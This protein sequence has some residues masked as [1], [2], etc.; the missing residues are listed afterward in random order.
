MGISKGFAPSGR[1]DEISQRNIQ[2]LRS[3]TSACPSSAFWPNFARRDGFA[4]ARAA[5]I[6]QESER[7][8]DVAEAVRFV[9]EA[10]GA[11][12]AATLAFSS[13]L[14]GTTYL[15]PLR[16][17]H[18]APLH[19]DEAARYDQVLRDIGVDLRV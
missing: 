4:C 18:N 6:V 11:L 2:K 15:L 3:C 16:C 5:A 7:A 12:Q 10:L 14:S 13:H 8:S 19:E 1:A 9:A 17:G